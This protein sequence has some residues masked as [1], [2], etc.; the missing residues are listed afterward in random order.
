M[1]VTLLDAAC[2]AGKIP[3]HYFQAVGSGTG[4]VAAWEAALRLSRDDSFGENRMKLHL[5][6]N[7][8]FVPMTDAWNRGSRKLDMPSEQEAKERI[9]RI[10]VKILSNRNPPYT[11]RGGVYDTLR[12]S[13][14]SMYAVTNQ[15][16][17]RA[18]SLFERMEGIDIHPAGGAAL[19]ALIQAVQSGGVD[20]DDCIALN[21]TGGGEKRVKQ[22]FDIH[23][24]QPSFSVDDREIHGN[25]TPE[26]IREMVLA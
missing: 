13:N 25:G 17:A 4:G 9:R 7:R 10:M 2:T 21:I 16:I 24:L 8:P 1:A 18:M 14:G 19:G 22:D 11:V 12:D 5:V 23:Q 3:D 26:K 6:Q 20:P 15:E